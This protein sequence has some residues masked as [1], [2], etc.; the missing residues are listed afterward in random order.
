[1]G[2]GVRGGE[3]VVR[4]D[5]NPRIG[6]GHVMRCLALAQAW[7]E[8]GGGVTFLSAS[9][10]PA[11]LKRIAQEGMRVVEL[12]VSAGDATDAAVT[13]EQASERNA[14]WVVLDGYQ[15]S[16]A[17][18]RTLKEAG[19]CLLA[20][21]DAAQAGHYWADLVLD[22]NFGAMPAQYTSAETGTRFLLGPRYTLLRKEFWKWRTWRR[23]VRG[24]VTNILIT[25]GGSDPDNLTGQ[26]VRAVGADKRD[27]R[28]VKVVVG[29][30]NLHTAEIQEA[31]KQA[32]TEIQVY[33]NAGDMSE[34]MAEADL[35]VIMAGGTLAETLFMGCGVLSYAHNAVQ[36]R[37]LQRL[38][39]QGMIRYLGAG[40]E[41]DAFDLLG[42]IEKMATD[43]SE[44]ERM[45]RMARGMIDGYGVERILQEME[46]VHAQQ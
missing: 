35:A 36:A 22:Q 5:A 45:S 29:A 4:A 33:P 23:E 37:I 1:M 40:A 25:L 27:D 44:R 17:Y 8:N 32:Q 15:F 28:V 31:A 13:A 2:A 9:T 20:I 34:L 14:D 41:L 10:T 38:D 42:Q 18:Q 16:S 39:G 7:R 11:L 3:L 43:A 19:I 46:T 26:I 12:E 24:Q 6:T 21:D 30:S